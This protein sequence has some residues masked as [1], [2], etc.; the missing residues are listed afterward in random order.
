VATLV[1]QRLLIDSDRP[2]RVIRA[3]QLLQLALLASYVPSLW[4]GKAESPR[5]NTIRFALFAVLL[6]VGGASVMH[7][8]PTPHIDVW[9][10]HDAGAK[11]LIHGRNP[12]IDVHVQETAGNEYVIAF[13]YPPTPCYL[14][15]IAYALGGDVRWGMLTALL[16]AGASMRVLARRSAAAPSTS[17]APGLLE[18]APA[19]LLWLSPKTFFLLEQSWNDIYP[20][21]FLALAVATH[22]YGKRHAAAAFLGLALSAKQTMILLVPLALLLGLSLGQWVTCLAVAAATLVPFLVADFSSLKGSIFDRYLTYAPRTDGLSAMIFL[23]KHFGVTPRSTPGLLFAAATI[24]LAV[25]RAPRTRYAFALASTL[26]ICLFFFFNIWM[27]VN[28][29]FF[30]AG[31]GLLTAATALSRSFRPDDQASGL[32]VH[33]EEESGRQELPDTL[34]DV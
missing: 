9:A 20:L 7:L 24:V 30:I 12:Y 26:A 25:W 18:D 17:G 14:N 10:V 5:W 11:A 22:A 31:L 3:V 29:Y 33:D 16:L 1:D 6:V 15:T 21:T 13:P 34:Q 19:L 23:H 27:F 8:S 28:N 32:P 4:S 2:P